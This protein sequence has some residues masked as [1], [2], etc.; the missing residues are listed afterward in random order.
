MTSG[1]ANTAACL[2]VCFSKGLLLL[3][4]TTHICLISSD[5]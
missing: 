5:I 1:K 3:T 2:V 4:A